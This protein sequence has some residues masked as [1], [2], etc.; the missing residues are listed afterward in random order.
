MKKKKSFYILARFH[1]FQI[2][3]K[4]PGGNLSGFLVPLIRKSS[5]IV[6]KKMTA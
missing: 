6:E 5:T 2:F 4:L 1:K 3:E